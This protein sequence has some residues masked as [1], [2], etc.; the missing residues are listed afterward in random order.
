LAFLVPIGAPLADARKRA[1]ECRTVRFDGI[2]PIEAR[3]AQREQK[4]LMRQNR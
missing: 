1:A 3:R 4:K 2:D